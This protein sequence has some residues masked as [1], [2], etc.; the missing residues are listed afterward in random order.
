MPPTT[1]TEGEHNSLEGPGGNEIRSTPVSAL[2]D[3]DNGT[4]TIADLLRELQETNRL[5]RNI[6]VDKSARHTSVL[7]ELLL[8]GTR[9]E[10]NQ[11]QVPSPPPL[12]SLQEKA[13]ELVEDLAHAAFNASISAAEMF[14]NHAISCMRRKEKDL[15]RPFSAEVHGLSGCAQ[16]RELVWQNFPQNWLAN[17]EFQLTNE[18][19][20]QLQRQWPN[21]T[22][23]D[24]L[25]G[26]S[27][28]ASGSI[29]NREIFSRGV[30][31][32]CPL[33]VD[34]EHRVFPATA[35]FMTAQSQEHN[36]IAT[37]MSSTNLVSPGAIWLITSPFGANKFFDLRQLALAAS[38]A[39]GDA[40][41]TWAMT[42]DNFLHGFCSPGSLTGPGVIDWSGSRGM[43]AYHHTFRY[44]AFSFHD[45]APVGSMDHAHASC[46]RE[47]G[48]LP[49]LLSPQTRVRNFSER[50]MSVLCRWSNID[51]AR[52]FR[53]VLLSDSLVV[54]RQ[55]DSSAGLFTDWEDRQFVV[56]GENAGYHMLQYVLH[57]I[58]IIWEEEW[59]SC[60]SLL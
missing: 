23:F 52:S 24:R 33:I 31:W 41:G 36:H 2:R 25:A 4:A 16:L 43:P 32:A 21:Q 35:L 40:D 48:G 30:I 11:E 55:S 20:E 14:R 42:A 34:S 9:V 29:L 22:D 47:G 17:D 49:S 58:L 39:L 3:Q 6:A 54:I 12:A 27:S 15:S 51:N 59:S 18:D 56:R 10:K 45:E 19:K 7:N 46:Y 57:R 8:P 5:L 1:S 26:T 38:L 60:L 44:F 13:N 28:K 53:I 37:K 50:R